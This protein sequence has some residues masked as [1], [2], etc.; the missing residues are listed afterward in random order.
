MGATTL[1]ATRTT[2]T[3]HTDHHRAVPVYAPAYYPVSYSTSY[4]YWPA[5]YPTSYAYDD[6]YYDY[7]YDNPVSAIG[8]SLAIMGIAG[9]AVVLIDAILSR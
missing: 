5:S 4:T 7:N 9:V 6:F 3:I 2:V 1:N 8:K